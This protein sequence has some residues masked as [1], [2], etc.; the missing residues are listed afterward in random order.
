MGFVLP[1]TVI[2]L[3]IVLLGKRSAGAPPHA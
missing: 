1:L 3:V 2:T